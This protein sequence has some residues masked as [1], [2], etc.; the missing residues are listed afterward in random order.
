MTAFSRLPDIVLGP[1][2]AAGADVWSRSV[3]GQWSPGEIV[4]HLVAAMER[5]ATGFESRADHA[6]MKRRPGTVFQRLARLMV[7]KAGRFGPKRKAPEGTGPPA[8]P[9]RAATEAAFR[10]CVQRF[11][12]L[13]RR[14]LPQ[15][16]RDLYLKHPVLGDL[17]LR[18]FMRFHVVHAKHHAKQIRQRMSG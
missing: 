6:P 1:L 16:E 18:E 9:D 15:R 17:T 4:A 11:L 14:L 7:L 8:S 13:E 12:D 10:S 2:T 5:S 3:D